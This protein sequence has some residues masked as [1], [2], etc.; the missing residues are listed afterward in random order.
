MTHPPDPAFGDDVARLSRRR[1]STV[2]RQLLAAVTGSPVIAPRL[3]HIREGPE[4]RHPYRNCKNEVLAL[5]S[6]KHRGFKSIGVP[7]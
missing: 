4:L 1:C 2:T 7:S 3:I 6:I 5:T